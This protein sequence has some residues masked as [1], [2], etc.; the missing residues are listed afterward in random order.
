[1]NN[2]T[3]LDS[4]DFE[5]IALDYSDR[6]FFKTFPYKITLTELYTDLEA[7][8]Y[9]HIL[10]Y[11]SMV[12]ASRD[13]I[14]DQIKDLATNGGVRVAACGLK[15]LKELCRME[16]DLESDHIAKV[17]D[18]YTCQLSFYPSRQTRKNNT[19]GNARLS[20]Y[21]FKVR[22]TFFIEDY[23]DLKS[24]TKWAKDQ[25]HLEIEAISGPHS[26]DHL[27]QMEDTAYKYEYSDRLYRN[28]YGSKLR[29]SLNLSSRKI[30]SRSSMK[31][32]IQ[33][34]LSSLMESTDDFTNGSDA[35]SNVSFYFTSLDDVKYS[36]PFLKLKFGSIIRSST[37]TQRILVEK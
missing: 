13:N 17:R 12:L 6:I 14:R 11:N 32:E 33:E 20:V 4:A 3:L 29:L 18:S 8:Y 37:I 35:W 21:R 7:Q 25:D 5:G 23:E 36:L 16:Y 26:A 1:M 22:H 31:N 34:Y 15:N 27:D 24:V 30:R 19:S 28:K 10:R 9:F 2:P